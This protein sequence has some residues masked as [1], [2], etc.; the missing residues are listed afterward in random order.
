MLFNSL[1]FLIFFPLVTGVYFLLKHRW[2]WAWL[3]AASCYF[4][5]CFVPVYILILAFTIVVDY[6]AGI[7]I[8]SSTG[9][10]RVYF[11]LASL[12][13]NIGVLCFFKYYNFINDSLTSL[14]GFAHI[15][16][17]IPHLDILLPIGLSFHTFQAISYTIEV[18]RG[19]QKAEKHFGIYALYVMFYP[20]L[21]AGPIERPQ[22][23]LH[24]FYEKHSFNYSRVSD[25]L[26]LML[27]GFFKKVV[28]ADRLA[29]LVNQVYNHPHNYEGVPLIIA[30][31]LF[32]FQIF[33]DFSGYSDIAIGA[34]N[35]MG[36]KLMTNFNKPYFSK[37]VDEFWK[38]WHISLSTWFRDYLYITI[39]GNRVS[40]P[41]WFFNLFVVFLISGLWH[42][43]NFTFIIWG[44]LHAIFMIVNVSYRLIIKK[45]SSKKEIKNTVFKN[46]LSTL[47]TFSVVCFAWI[48]FRANNVYDAYYI[49]THLL[50]DIPIQIKNMVTNIDDRNHLLFLDKNYL[51]LVVGVLSIVVMEIVHLNTRKKSLTQWMAS[52]PVWMRWMIYY[53]L[54]LSIIF[55]GVYD[56][57]QQFIYFQF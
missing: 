4:Y 37:S 46:V 47:L 34:A 9:K 27:W 45:Y 18:Y 1:Q 3:L 25:G 40:I 10:K 32:A 13:A 15:K 8:D 20:Q 42:G 44:F 16:N 33:C 28:I 12:V 14:L 51:Q 24:Q 56:H 22:N 54:V 11:L 53:G 55:F 50:A 41:R 30:T 29:V 6:I 48:F 7:Y 39:G 2:R 5:M 49:T 21:V 35:V 23:L 17:S 43:A 26:K 31:V 57:A 19:N 52:K 38:R 36:F